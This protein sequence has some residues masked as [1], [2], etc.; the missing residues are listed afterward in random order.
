MDVN[1]LSEN[2]FNRSVLILVTHKS[3][4]YNLLHKNDHVFGLKSDLFFGIVKHLYI[5]MR[6][7]K[8]LKLF[9]IYTTKLWLLWKT[10]VND[11]SPSDNLPQDISPQDISPLKYHTKKAKFK[12]INIPYLMGGEIWKW[13]T[14]QKLCIFLR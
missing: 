8:V 5:Y 9:S 10:W 7:K 14:V 2:I 11:I 6:Q 1:R 13:G 12:N 3:Y 4:L